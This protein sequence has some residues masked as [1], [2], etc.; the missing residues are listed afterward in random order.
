MVEDVVDLLPESPAAFE[1]ALEDGQVLTD[2]WPLEDA[3]S[4]VPVAT[5]ATAVEDAAATP[6]MPADAT[7]ALISAWVTSGTS[8]FWVY[9]QPMGS[10]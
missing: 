9:I 1:S 2:A 3:A 4:A 7:A 10:F 5:A 6:L 8:K